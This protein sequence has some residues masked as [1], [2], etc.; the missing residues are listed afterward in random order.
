MDA[1][2]AL[3]LNQFAHTAGHFD[4][5]GKEGADIS[6]HGTDLAE[7]WNYAPDYYTQRPMVVP[8]RGSKGRPTLETRM[9]TEPH[10]EKDPAK[11]N[12][13][14]HGGGLS[15]Q[16]ELG[17]ALQDP[18][19]D[20]AEAIYKLLYLTGLQNRLGK[21]ING[22]IRNLER[23]SGNKNVDTLVALS[24][25]DDW[26]RSRNPDSNWRFDFRT[27]DGAPGGMVSLRMK[28]IPGEK[29]LDKFAP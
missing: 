21:N 2:T 24:A 28:D 10:Y 11:V 4:R 22:D 25:L 15:M 14:I 19:Y 23:S 17:G 26:R 3:I 5:A 12:S 7:R 8:K 1:L 27:F 6:L 29:L 20:N 18:A 16:G 9:I 13:E